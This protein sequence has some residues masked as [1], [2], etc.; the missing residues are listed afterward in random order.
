MNEDDLNVLFRILNRHDE[1]C[2]VLRE[3]NAGDAE[4]L[5]ELDEC[6]A[7]LERGIQLL[8]KLKSEA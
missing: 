2:R 1:D 4:A 8:T 7:D 6:E 5:A 3:T